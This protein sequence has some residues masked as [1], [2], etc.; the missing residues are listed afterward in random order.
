MSRKYA[1]FEA[2]RSG[3]VRVLHEQLVAAPAC[4]HERSITGMLPY[5]VAVDCHRWDLVLALLRVD[6]NQIAPPKKV[7]LLQQAITRSLPEA[8]IIELVLAAPTTIC[9]PNPSTFLGTI[10]YPI[11]AVIAAGF[12]DAVVTIL[13]Q[14]PDQLSVRDNDGNSIAHL[15]CQNTALHPGVVDAIAELQPTLLRASCTNDDG[16]TP[17][18]VAIE[19]H[20]TSSAVFQSIRACQALAHP[21]ICLARD[22]QGCLP[23]HVA[24]VEHDWPAVDLLASWCPEA[25]SIPD[26]IGD[27]P[28]HVAAAHRRW[29]L[30]LLLVKFAPS[31]ASQ[32]DRLGRSMLE[33]A[34]GSQAWPCA[35][36]LVG[37]E[38]S[39]LA[40][41]D[42]DSVVQHQQ[43]DLAA[44]L[45]Y[46]MT[47][48]LANPAHT[49]YLSSKYGA[50]SFIVAAVASMAPGVRILDSG[51]PLDVA[52]KHQHWDTAA[53]LLSLHLPA[54][55]QKNAARLLPLQVAT[56]QDAP[57]W[58]LEK[59]ADAYPSAALCLDAKGNPLV[60]VMCQR[61]RWP[62]VDALLT[63]APRAVDKRDGQGYT[64]LERAIQM[65]APVAVVLRVFTA[66]PFTCTR[67]GIWCLGAVLDHYALSFKGADLEVLAKAVASQAFRDAQGNS[68]LHLA[69]AS[70]NVLFCRALLQHATDIFGA[71]AAGASPH[72]LAL[73]ASSLELR[74]LFEPLDGTAGGA[75][76]HWLATRDCDGKAPLDHAIAAGLLRVVQWMLQK[77]AEPPVPT[78]VVDASSDVPLPTQAAIGV[79]LAA[80]HHGRLVLHGR[81]LLSPA[82]CD[83]T[84][85]LA[86]RGL[87]L[88][89]G[90]YV[91]VL[92]YESADKCKVDCAAIQTAQ[93]HSLRI[94]GIV[95][96]FCER[97]VYY[98][99][100]QAGGASLP[101]WL[102][103]ERSTYERRQVAEAVCR[104]VYDLHVR[105]QHVALALSTSSFEETGPGDFKFVDV[106][107]CAAVGAVVSPAA[108]LGA[109][110]DPKNLRFLSPRLAAS[111]LPVPMADDMETCLTVELEDNLWSLGV[112]LFEL[113][114]SEPWLGTACFGI[115]ESAH[116]VSAQTLPDAEAKVLAQ[117]FPGPMQQVVLLLFAATHS[118]SDVL[119]LDYFSAPR[120]EP[121]ATLEPPPP[122]AFQPWSPPELVALALESHRQ[123]FSSVVQQQ[124][125]HAKIVAKAEKKLQRLHCDVAAAIDVK[126]HAL[127]SKLSHMQAQLEAI[128]I[129]AAPSPVA[130]P[131]M[132]HLDPVPSQTTLATS[133]SNG[134]VV[135][136]DAPSPATPEAA[137]P[138]SIEEAVC[139]S[140]L[141]QRVRKAFDDGNVYHGTITALRYV[142][143]PRRANALW[144]IEYEDGDNEE[145]AAAELDDILLTPPS[146][147]A[148]LAPKKPKLRGHFAQ[149]R[150]A[151]GQTVWLLDN[152]KLVASAVVC[153]PPAQLAAVSTDAEV[154]LHVTK[155]FRGTTAPRR[156]VP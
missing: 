119:K 138:T 26:P 140:Y 100:L 76:A 89:S 61:Q 52:L 5:E 40:A 132:S 122:S 142:G 108:V 128:Q 137:A 87:D 43:W 10:E 134:L 45:L 99:I 92:G 41:Y 58:L 80:A 83:A 84:E 9:A 111:L 20:N 130:Q 65:V 93:R 118:I 116:Q 68:A 49:M 96:A 24:L 139:A 50:P 115:Y 44:M 123:Q 53:C 22:H 97:G 105:A 51:R 150:P 64:V 106:L 94:A 46:A 77:G 127:E 63:A 30:V 27:L 156:L 133:K 34:L 12:G 35:K 86:A 81:Y 90:A 149:T 59:L 37:L 135:A 103:S 88:A 85:V 1:I 121:V 104:S 101:T 33:V 54:A 13:R 154:V 17:L 15:V 146:F 143:S 16:Q 55:R 117:G 145:V 113:W 18:H 155:Y 112:V 152:R 32:R 69:V 48:P 91:R 62:C 136:S 151:V 31:T 120:Q 6:A 3:D 66:A 126:A 23:L 75:P 141:N 153:E 47:G 147:P 71:N 95:D 70:G 56:A 114:S 25:V 125:D 109:L 129:P 4:V 2:V 102:T 11:H 110:G 79:E 67:D 39:H 28:L 21:S 38:E 148:L 36:I 19:A 98:A 82:D 8:Q 7:S 72:A 57:A 74:R 144:A 14:C 60:H 29:D 131:P 124:A 78:Q 73:Q 107:Q 42:I